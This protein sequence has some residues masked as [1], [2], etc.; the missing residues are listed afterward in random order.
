[1]AGRRRKNDP[2]NALFRQYVR[3]VEALEPSLLL[4]ENVR[5]IDVEFGKKKKGSQ[6]KRGPGRPPTPFS[7]KIKLKLESIGYVV[8][9]KLVK[10]LDFG[11]AQRRP[12][13]LIIAVRRELLNG[14][15]L[16]DPFE[17][18]ETIRLNF[19]K[20]KE[21][22]NDKPISVKEALSD[23]E[24]TGKT[25]IDCLDSPGFKQIVY[26]APLTAYQRL[27]HG[28]MNGSAPNSLRLA[29]HRDT[30]R[31]RFAGI[32]ATCRR[33]V[34][35]SKQDRER[36]GLGKHCTVPLDPSMPS[37][38]L[39]TLPDDILHYSEPRIL[40]V[41]EYARLQSFPD[42]Y[43][44]KGKYTTGGERRVRECPRYTQVGNAVPPFLSECLGL[45]LKDLA[46][47]LRQTP[48]SKSLPE[49]AIA[50]VAE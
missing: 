44:F 16:F 26:S 41:R 2:R 23:L 46:S 19:L 43:A 18:L 47:G 9:P 32:L 6:R 36:L 48:Q 30:I 45:L 20:A 49:K 37:H 38:T 27:L 29:K 39:T 11:V 12:R 31:E 33:G 42:W 21:L 15:E 4:L 22:P 25:L 34:Q 8:F 28:S 14:R 17:N 13:Y 7:Q 10:A 40:C 3:V 1:M 35:L 5:G 24:V 50:K